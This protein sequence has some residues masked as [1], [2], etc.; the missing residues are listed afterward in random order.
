LKVTNLS[1][2]PVT[3]NPFFTV[4]GADFSIGAL[5]SGSCT[6]G[7]QP[8][9]SCI[10]PLRFNP[11]SPG[12]KTGS[13]QLTASDGRAYSV[14][15]AGYAYGAIGITEQAAASGSA[16]LYIARA[17][18]GN[19]WFTVQP[20]ARPD[21]VAR[22]RPDGEITEYPISDAAGGAFDIAAGSD[23]NMWFTIL[24]AGKIGRITPEGVLTEFALPDPAS[25]P[26]GIALGSDGNMWFT[27]IVGQRIGRIA[28]NGTITEFAVPWQSTPRGI[29]SGPDGNLW[30]T[31]SG[32]LSIG[33]VS[34]GGQFT[35]FQ[36]PW[37]SASVRG[38]ARGADGNL[39]FAENAGNRI[40]RIT[41]SG[42][43]TEFPMP[44]AGTNPLHIAAGPDGAMWFTANGA[45]RVGRIDIATGQVSE[46]RLPSAGSTP[47]GIVEGSNRQMW[48]PGNAS[49]KIAKLSIPG[50]SGAH[51]YSDLWWSGQAE[52]GWGMTINQ[53]GNTQFIVLFVYDN[54]GR[55]AW[56]VMPGCAWNADFTSCNGQLYKPRSAPLN[57]YTPAQFAAGSPV[58]TITLQYTGASTATIQYVINGVPGQKSISRQ[59]FGTSDN[60][61][62]LQVGDMWWAGTTQDGWGISIT[63]QYRNLFAAWYTYDASGN[64]TWFVMPAGTWSGNSYA[65]KLYSTTS[66]A[67][68]G[69]PYNAG[70]FNALE[71]G[72]LTLNFA[73]ANSGSMTYA[74]TAGPFAGTTQTKPLERQPF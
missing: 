64:V 34:V 73:S 17:P 36:I 3:I 68:L 35:R 43:F 11:A 18:D 53:H 48:V 13:M 47:I 30:F 4:T 61:P 70:A 7:L 37:A 74:F 23:G 38:I 19:Y 5:V 49:S 14:A 63:Q 65:G 66:S 22:M 26:R 20:P 15:L 6:G 21:G 52:N 33:R 8:D 28:P 71:V 27:E 32:G 55:P 39:W 16:P 54:A 1:P 2:A 51:V 42:T 10:V 25:Q 62:G 44:R 58:G 59:V 57:N 46:Y 40:G 31:D 45:N 9:A 56:Y 29:T 72:T 12:F 41:P 67:W 60:T 50:V 24:N 69:V